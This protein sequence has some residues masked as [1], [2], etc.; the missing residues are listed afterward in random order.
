[1]PGLSHRKVSWVTVLG[2]EG[3]WAQTLCLWLFKYVINSLWCL[4]SGSFVT[5][6]QCS[7]NLPCFSFP[8]CPLPFPPYGTLCWWLPAQSDFGVSPH[9]TLPLGVRNL[10]I[11]DCPP[12]YT[13]SLVC[14]QFK[15]AHLDSTFLFHFVPLKKKKEEQQQK[16]SIY[17]MPFR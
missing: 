13:S 7:W 1:M 12:G 9:I 15:A 2:S 8:G 16:T 17:H 10:L 5:G 11:P 14:S 4:L 6:G 3:I